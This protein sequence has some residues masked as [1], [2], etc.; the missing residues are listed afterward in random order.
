M[1]IIDA[2]KLRKQR[3]ATRYCFA[4]AQLPPITAPKMNL[5]P[6]DF[7][8]P[9]IL[10]QGIT[11]PTK[12]PQARAVPVTRPIHRPRL[13]SS[14]R[15][16]DE[17][18]RT[19]VKSARVSRAASSARGNRSARSDQNMAWEC[20]GAFSRVWAPTSDIEN[21]FHLG[22]HRLSGEGNL[23]SP[24][25]CS[26]GSSVPNRWQLPPENPCSSLCSVPLHAAITEH[27]SKKILPWVH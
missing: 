1:S 21:Q 17:R 27:A 25:W 16:D 13:S 11:T 9:A 7:I 23:R 26:C 12:S 24:W 8:S 4:L 2:M 10:G 20:R 15:N 6:L 19:T 14:F 18:R 22:A 3:R 5:P